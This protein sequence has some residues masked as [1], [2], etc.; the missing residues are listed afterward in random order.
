VSASSVQITLWLGR[1]EAWP[2]PAEIVSAI[3]SIEIAQTSEGRSGFQIAFAAGR[4]SG[5]SVDYPL[6]DHPLLLPYNRVVIMVTLNGSTTVL[7]DGVITNRQLVP[8]D[9][10]G[11]PVFAITGQDVSVMMDMIEYSMEYPACSAEMQVAAIVA[12]NIEFGLIPIIIPTFFPDVPIPTNSV[13]IQVG[14]DYQHAKKL[15]DLVGWEF[16]VS[17]GPEPLTNYC[18]WGPPIRIGLPQPAINVDM[19]SQSNAHNVKFSY[20]ATPPTLVYGTVKDLDIPFMITPVVTFASMHLPPLAA[21]PALYM[22]LPFVKLRIL[23]SSG[24]DTIGAWAK[25]QGITDRSTDEVLTA[26]GE[27]DTL[28]Y[29][30]VLT[31]RSLVGVRGVGYMHDGMY[32]VRNVTHRINPRGYQQSFTLVR[33]GY[34]S[35]VDSVMT[36]ALD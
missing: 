29:G 27:L 33:E 3:Q 22:G 23:D 34:G 14:T 16:F 19:G 15:A 18:Y 6:V 30:S 12:K 11:S 24:L 28:K 35:T 17:P 8:G 5:V 20:E 32:Y 36:S 4:P 13:P 21:V 10:P 31:A 2:A 7:M 9:G 26:T 1:V 25:A